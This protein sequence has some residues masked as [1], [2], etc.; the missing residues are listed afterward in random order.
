MTVR[1]KALRSFGIPRANEGHI[2]RGREFVV[3]DDRR[4]KELEAHGLAF[5]V[6]A[7]LAPGASMTME[8]SLPPPNEAAEQGPF[9]LDGGQTGEDAPVPSSHQGRQ[10]RRR[11]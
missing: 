9:V 5:R 6:E 7:K 2:K 10:R 4:C 1:M 3:V 11:R 8:T